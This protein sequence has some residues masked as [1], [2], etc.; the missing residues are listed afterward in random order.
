MRKVN[1]AILGLGTVGSGVYKV[2]EAE[3]EAIMHKEGLDLAVKKVLALQYSIPIPEELKA[4]DIEEVVSDPEI[5]VV[6]EVMGG[7]E[8]AKTFITKAL[9]HSKTVVTANKELLARHWPDLEKVAKE[10]GAGLYF[11]ASVGGGIPILRTVWDSLQANTIKSIFGIING[12][13]NYILTKMTDEGRDFDEVLKQAQELG[14]AEANP[15]NDIEAYDTMYKL[16]IL[17]SMAFHA[18]IPVDYIYREGITK[19]SKLDIQYGKALGY[20]V[21]LL[22]IGKKEGETVQVRVHPTMIP[23]THPLANVKDSFN[24]IFLDGSQVGEVMFYGKG[25]GD[26]PT[27]SAIVS[28]IIYSCQVAKHKYATFSNTTEISPTLIFENNWETEFFI[29]LNVKDEP[30]VMAKIA[31]VFGKYGV[32]IKSILQPGEEEQDGV[33]LMIVTHKARE[34][35]VKKAI[36]EIKY[37]KE[38][39]DVANMIRVER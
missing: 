26:L 6:V 37:I 8:P 36:D 7:I 24:A 27:A 20:E 10:N 32:S 4:S 13:T 38:I 34:I 23:K 19:I 22:A 3:H 25:A 28:D 35:S 18:R 11:E 30:G 15:T 1:I 21:K 39:I 16:S 31:T 33:P 14:Y 29:R 2:I 17:A 9:S 12:T 5:D